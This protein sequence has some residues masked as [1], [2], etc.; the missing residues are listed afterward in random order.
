MK[1]KLLKDVALPHNGT[2]D[3]APTGQPLV[4]A[5]GQVVELEDAQAKAYIKRHLATAVEASE[6]KQEK[7]AEART[8]KPAKGPTETK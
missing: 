4:G 5:A 3:T 2:K 6:A 1:V 8:T 7:P